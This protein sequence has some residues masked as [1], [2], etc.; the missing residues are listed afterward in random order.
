[1]PGASRLSNGIASSTKASDLKHDHNHEHPNL[2]KEAINL[3]NIDAIASTLSALSPIPDLVISN[4]HGGDFELQSR[5]IAAVIKVGIARFMPAEFSHDST[6]PTVRDLLPPFKERARVIGLLKQQR[7]ILWVGLASGY[8][9]DTRLLNGH[10]GIDLTWQSSTVYGSGD[11]FFPASSTAFVGK[12]V[13][14]IA[15]HWG[16]LENQYVCVA[17][18]QTSFNEVLTMLERETGKDWSTVYVEREKCGEEAEKRMQ[19]GWPDAGMFLMER[20]LLSD[21]RASSGFGHDAELRKRI[22]LDPEDL[23]SVLRQVLHDLRHRS[24]GCGCD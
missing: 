23:K 12:A 14:G 22:G 18:V 6:N 21:D 9:I 11:V 24:E 15:D 1:M 4:Y 13:A 19:G 3:S 5:V 8:S 10:M 7:N 16:Q 20:S 2:S 17:G